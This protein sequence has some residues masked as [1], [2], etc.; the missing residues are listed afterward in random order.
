MLVPETPA[1]HYA[2]RCR[3]CNCTI[4]DD[5]F[6]LGCSAL[7]EPALLIADYQ[8]HR[9]QPDRSSADLFRFRQWLPT[10][11]RMDGSGSGITY[12]SDRLARAA[13]LDELWI[14][15][16]GWW[17]ERGAS[18]ATA[19]F[20][21]LEAWTVLARLP[22]RP[23]GTLVLASAGNT[24]AAFARACSLAGVP[25]LII[26]PESGL[27]HLRLPEERAPWVKLVVLEPPADYTDAIALA[28]WLSEVDGYYPEGGVRNVARRAGLGTV[29]LDASDT[30]GR[31]PDYYFQ[32]VGS[33]AGA[34]GVFES[35]ER[36][37][38]DGRYGDRPPRLML[39]Q[40]RPFTPLYDSWRAG[41]RALMRID[42]DAARR[43]AAELSA[44]VLSNREPPYAVHG[45]VYDV[46][47]L[48]GGDM[49]AVDNSAARRARALFE[50]LEGIDIDP[51]SA[52][53]LAS[54]LQAARD[55]RI[56]PGATVLLNVTGGGRERLRR[57]GALRDARPD[58]RLAGNELRRS[59]AVERVGAL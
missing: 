57:E 35:A 20:K 17:P 13:G 26:V 9:F 51:A 33:G 15:F 49:L 3:A 31:L 43:C 28:G 8:D 40:N 59:G 34:I 52:V 21:E 11:R 53:G 38:E 36:L 41:G 50:D 54:L 7:H 12:R 39:S 1:R 55:G 29:L 22:R 44:P 27:A 5:G 30:M 58:I 48:T 14:S 45:G 19:T 37:V 4:E 24:A 2:L 25:C 18:L 32:A 47:S 16:N 56:F 10:A 23:A 46:L 6:V 42:A